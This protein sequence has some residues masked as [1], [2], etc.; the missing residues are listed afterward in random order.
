VTARHRLVAALL[1]ASTACTQW[2][3]VSLTDVRAGTLDL[4]AERV[5]FTAAEGSRD[6]RVTTAIG[7]FAQGVDLETGRGVRVDL[8]RVRGVEVRRPDHLL[9]ALIVG[10]IYL[11][12]FVLGGLGVAEGLPPLFGDR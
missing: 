8:E 10:G 12:V 2:R 3:A 9:N 6:L 11:S 4:R 1:V 5:R 7:P